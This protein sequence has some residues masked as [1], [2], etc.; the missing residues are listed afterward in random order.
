VPAKL[1]ARARLLGGGSARKTDR[2]D[3]ASV[4][5]VAQ[6]HRHLLT[7]QPEG[8]EALLR[9]LSERRDDLV[10]EL[11]AAGDN[12]DRM[13]SES[14]FAHLCGVA[15]V[16]ASSGKTTRY[17]LNRGGD[18]QANYALYILAVTRLAWDPA[19]A[20]TPP[21]AA[22]RARQPR[23]SS[24]ASLDDYGSCRSW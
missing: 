15:P 17:R 13:R 5:A 24:A 18:R 8:V 9:L 14:A 7:V 11:I 3:A 16:P 2:T 20:P 1:A 19:P 6:H 23:R 21:G 10:N 22:P 4:A 12:P